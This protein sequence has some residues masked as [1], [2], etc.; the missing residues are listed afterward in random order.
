MENIKTSNYALVMAVALLV[1]T[2]A[3]CGGG[4]S[5]GGSGGSDNNDSI[6]MAMDKP[7]SSVGVITSFGSVVVNGVH[8]NSDSSKISIDGVDGTENGLT[9]G[10]EVKILGRLSEDEAEGE[11]DS[12][13]YNPHI[14]GVIETIDLVA[15]RFVVLGQTI[16]TDELTNFEGFE[17][18][19]LKVGDRVEVSAQMDEDGNWIA[20]FVELEDGIDTLMHIRSEITNLNLENSSFTAGDLTID[21]SLA[22]I[23]NAPEGGLINGLKVKVESDALPMDG[24]LLA[25][26]IK[27]ET[28]FDDSNSDDGRHYHIEGTITVFDSSTVFTVN[29][30]SVMTNSTTRYIQGDENSLELGIKI[31][32]KGIRDQDSV[33]VAEQIYIN[34]PGVLKM[35]GAVEAVDVPAG[36]L[37]LLGVAINVN[38]Q[39]H[40]KDHSSHDNKRLSLDDF[41]IGDG[42]EL[43]GFVQSD[44]TILAKKIE[45]ESFSGESHEDEELELIGFV[46]SVEQPTFVINDVTITTSEETEFEGLD[47]ELLTQEQFFSLLEEDTYV[48]VEGSLD[49]AGGFIAAEAE[50]KNI[51]SA[52][53]DNTDDSGDT[54]GSGDSGDSGD[55][56]GNSGRVELE[57]VIDTFTSASEF[58][59][60]GHGVVTAGA[61]RFKNGNET[62]LA[63]G[64]SVEIKGFLME[65]GI[66]SAT[67]IEIEH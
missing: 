50:L 15:L 22:E 23:K 63:V 10:M 19:E 67:R 36:T 3:S 28:E 60:N 5:S 2:F 43:K 4:G 62:D 9:I 35:K 42:I 27:V 55:S 51:D 41:V 33:L 45:R 61:T 32:V 39:T 46:S 11:A 49:D 26:E 30:Q 52:S 37:T 25:T 58:T 16:I 57:G 20:G 53:S 1:M 34:K 6:E 47:D 21:F 59:V 29:G 48:K 38:D 13:E 66:V 18:S 40:F 24:V 14:R 17:F 56:R 31:K 44:G 65:D 7:I 8:Y 54:D 12:I 64:V